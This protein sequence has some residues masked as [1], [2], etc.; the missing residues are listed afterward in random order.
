[1]AFKGRHYWF[2]ERIA[3]TFG[4]DISESEAKDF[5]RA[6]LPAFNALLGGE[7]APALFVF[8]QARGGEGA[9]AAAA[10]RGEEIRPELYL[11]DSADEQLRSICCYFARG[12]ATAKAGDDCEP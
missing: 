5:V 8:Y 2:A 11:A 9:A 12:G 4:P 7:G 1:M 6:Q 10:V 3:Q